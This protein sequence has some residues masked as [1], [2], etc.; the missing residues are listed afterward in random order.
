MSTESCAILLALSSAYT[1]ARR[2]VQPALCYRKSYKNNII[3][4]I[5][6]GAGVTDGGGITVGEE[7]LVNDKCH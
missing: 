5:R 1:T 2:P 7:A 3:P 4:I 6:R